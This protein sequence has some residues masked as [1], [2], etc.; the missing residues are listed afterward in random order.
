MNS[1]LIPLNLG[2]RAKILWIECHSNRI[3]YCTAWKQIALES[4]A[5]LSIEINMSKAI[6][7]QT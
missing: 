3:G 1:A 4:Q 5:V 2:Q 7:S 6:L